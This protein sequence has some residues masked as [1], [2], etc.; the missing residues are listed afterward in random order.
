MCHDFLALAFGIDRDGVAVGFFVFHQY[1][2]RKSQSGGWLLGVLFVG[3]LF[4]SKSKETKYI[5]QH[6]SA[7]KTS[8]KNK[9]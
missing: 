2:K 3:C 6:K 9:G 1:S 8:E 4:S 5:F 7:E